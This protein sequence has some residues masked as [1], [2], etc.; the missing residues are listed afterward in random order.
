MIEHGVRRHARP[1]AVATNPQRQGWTPS[2]RKV[3]G[4]SNHLGSHGALI[5]GTFSSLH[6]GEVEARTGYTVER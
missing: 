2:A 5:C 1:K 3:N 6:V 4:L